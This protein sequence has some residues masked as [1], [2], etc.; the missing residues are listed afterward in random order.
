ME[1]KQ[2][3]RQW[4]DDLEAQGK[5]VKV[6]WEGGNDDGAF[7]AFIDDEEID[8]D[9]S[10]NIGGKLIDIVADEIAYGSF[11]GDYSTNG[12]L[13][14]ADGE[15]TGIDNYSC[16]EQGCVELEKSKYIKIEI[17]EYI[18]FDT[19][20]ISTEGHTD[21][22]VQASF[23]FN[24]TNG[25]VVEEHALLEDELAD[26]ISEA[27]TD[28][29]NSVQE[30]IN[31]IYNEWPFRFEDGV[32]QNGKRIF[33]IEEIDYNYECGEDKQ[34]CFEITDDSEEQML[35]KKR[36]DEERWNKFRDDM[37]KNVTNS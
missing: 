3:L 4:L 19:I 8:T 36:E 15:M 21:D 14:Y 18:W 9:G 11:A 25:P 34:I 33:Y 20:N 31:Y 30:D 17:P 1:E 7:H 2:T 26:K 28:R 5:E 35:E 32:L 22:G 27:V 37:N 29:L 24:I 12:E 13:I 10:N 16:S 6:T 23:N